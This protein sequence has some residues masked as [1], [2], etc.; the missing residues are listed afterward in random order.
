MKV[1]PSA[2]HRVMATFIRQMYEAL[3]DEGFTESQTIKILAEMTASMA[4]P[5]EPTE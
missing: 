1:E 5:Q 4:R 2:D 3:T